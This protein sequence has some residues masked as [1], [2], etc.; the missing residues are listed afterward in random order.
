MSTERNTGST[1]GTTSGTIPGTIEGFL[2]VTDVEAVGVEVVRE[3][4]LAGD[5]I[6]LSVRVLSDDLHHLLLD[7]GIGHGHDSLNLLWAHGAL[8]PGANPQRGTVRV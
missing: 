4:G 5:R 2:P 1:S 3:A 7:L 6:R 8:L